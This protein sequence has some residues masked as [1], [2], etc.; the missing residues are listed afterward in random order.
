MKLVAEFPNA[1]FWCGDSM[2]APLQ[3]QI[4]ENGY[5]TAVTD[6]PA[7]LASRFWCALPGVTDF[8]VFAGLKKDPSVIAEKILA[9]QHFMRGELGLSGNVTVEAALSHDEEDIQ[10][11]ISSWAGDLFGNH[12]KKHELIYDQECKDCL[13]PG[14][15]SM[16]IEHSGLFGMAADVVFDPFC[17]NGSTAIAAQALGMDFI[18]IDADKE[19]VLIA[20]DKYARSLVV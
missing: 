16:C 10:F 8:L 6:P 20:A 12:L 14:F 4:R 1:Q 11:C 19:R 18:G 5:V 9:C 13:H 2:S 17:G 3:D 15:V 7:H